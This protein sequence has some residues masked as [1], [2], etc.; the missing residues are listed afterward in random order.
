MDYP[1]PNH[2]FLGF[3]KNEYGHTVTRHRC[4]TCGDE[5]T[6]CPPIK[7]D[8][9]HMWEGCLA[10]GCDSYDPRRDVDKLWDNGADIIRIS[11][12]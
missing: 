5:F 11:H 1:P 9:L 4:T 10:V 6:M 3:T 12:N 8:R 2:T 7:P